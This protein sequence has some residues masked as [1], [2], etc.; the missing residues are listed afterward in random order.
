M[1]GEEE[2]VGGQVKREEV[3]EKKERKT[4]GKADVL[5]EGWGERQTGV[6]MMKRNNGNGSP[7][8]WK[9][10]R[11]IWTFEHLFIDILHDVKYVI[12]YLFG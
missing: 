4:E 12:T 1:S 9:E 8:G 5:C 11:E 10:E 2:C 7:T 3:R 6:A